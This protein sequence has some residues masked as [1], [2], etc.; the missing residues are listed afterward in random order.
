M[1]KIS[2]IALTAAAIYA[3]S[4]CEKELPYPIDGVKRGVLIDIA[5]IPGSNG[6]LEA[7]QTTGNYQVMLTIPE[8]QGDYSSLDHAQLL[9]VLTGTD[10][11]TSARVVV[12][13]ITSFPQKID[14]DIAGVYGKFNLAGP[15]SGEVLYFTANVV[16]K[17][18]D[19]IPGWS[20]H[21]GFNNRA[22]SGW[23]VDNRAYSYNVRYPVVC[24]LNLDDFVGDKTIDDPDWWEDSYLV[25][26]E[27]LSETEL[28]VS[29]LFEGDA[30]NN[31]IITI[32]PSLH[33]VTIEKQV[34]VVADKWWGAGYTNFSLEGSG[35]IDACN[36]KITFTATAS[37]TQGIFGE[38][39]FT[40][41]AN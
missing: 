37:V 28:S 19:V 4:G 17:N 2:L 33:T 23:R 30:D 21:A 11:V 13:N 41:Y 12:D 14:I 35:T 18:G 6:L 34:L 8:Y 10:G 27:K 7:G 20:E 1:K 5:R 38:A 36:G 22:F 26:V 32:D 15:S 25:E 31:L 16:L 9:A 24:Q 40:I 39:S 29:G 3:F